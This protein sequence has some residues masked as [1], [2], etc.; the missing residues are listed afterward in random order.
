MVKDTSENDKFKLSI[1]KKAPINV[2]WMENLKKSQ[3]NPAEA[4]RVFVDEQGNKYKRCQCCHRIFYPTPGHELDQRYC[5]DAECE[6]QRTNYRARVHYR[7]DSLD[8]Q[9]RALRFEQKQLERKNRAALQGLEPSSSSSGR[10]RNGMRRNL[11]D[12]RGSLMKLWEVIEGMLIAFGHK[13]A[14]A[15]NEKIHQLMKLG[16]ELIL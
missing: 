7:K 15:V 2:E 10:K 4:N 11:H 16:K 12:V 8:P 1:R 13:T 9:R 6:R 3:E 14:N 5:K